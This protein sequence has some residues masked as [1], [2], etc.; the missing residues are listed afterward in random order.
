MQALSCS[1]SLLDLSAGR[2]CFL[3]PGTSVQLH[4]ASGSAGELAMRAG[5]GRHQHA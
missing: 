1:T 3:C 4:F 2:V 5:G